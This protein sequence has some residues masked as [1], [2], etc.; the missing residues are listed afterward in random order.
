MTE[1]TDIEAH[2][3]ALTGH[4]YQM[5]GSLFDAD[6]A[7]QETMIR[8]WRALDQSDGRS[9]VRTWLYR[10]RPLAGE[11]FHILLCIILT[12]RQLLKPMHLI[13]AARR[14][15]P[16]IRVVLASAALHRR[17]GLAVRYGLSISL[18][19]VRRM[20]RVVLRFDAVRHP[21]LMQD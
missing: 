1:L 3:P 12:T 7:V 5:L 14:V 21:A 4:C 2:R 9:S 17:S 15:F 10:I 6:D 8:A 11:L 19:L 18:F 13:E 16:F 20:S